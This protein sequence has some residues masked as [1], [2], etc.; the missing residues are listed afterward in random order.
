MLSVNVR[1]K[2]VKDETDLRHAPGEMEWQFTETRRVTGQQGRT[3]LRS[4][5]ACFRPVASGGSLAALSLLLYT[6]AASE[7]L[8]LLVTLLAH[9]KWQ[10][11]LVICL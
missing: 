8:M 3:V 1:K 7:V 5:G 4:S 2:R 6:V 9:V 10:H 11:L